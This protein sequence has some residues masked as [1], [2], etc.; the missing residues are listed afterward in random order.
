MKLY[1]INEAI[2]N[3]LIN[4]IDEETGELD[5]EKYEAELAE[6]QIAKD[7]KIK[8]TALLI[9]NLRADAEALAEQEKKFKQ[10]KQAV[11][12]LEKRILERLQ[13]DLK[14][15]S[16]KCTEVEIKYSKS[17]RVEVINEVDFE[18]FA[19][20]HPEFAIAEIKPDKTA[21]KQAIERGEEIPG[22][23]IVE[24]QNMQIK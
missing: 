11:Q 8:N 9:I 23:E 5:F 24:K 1:E 14:G 18:L 2:E 12:N 16:F 17:K 21:I 19:T 20:E 13:F 6:L 22:C 7:E 3:A 10:R 15:E 4:S